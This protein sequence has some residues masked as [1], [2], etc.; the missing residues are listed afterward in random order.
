MFAL[1]GG[2]CVL[3]GN[4]MA[5]FALSLGGMAV[6]VIIY[7]NQLKSALSMAKE[8]LEDFKSKKA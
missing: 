1:T 2:A 4:F 7:H 6:Y 8:M 5:K 3:S